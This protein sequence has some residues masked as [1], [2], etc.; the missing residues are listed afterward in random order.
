MGES[1]RGRCGGWRRSIG[2][3]GWRGIG[4]GG[5]RRA[6]GG[7][8]KRL[9]SI[10]SQD[11][12]FH[13]GLTNR[14]MRLTGHIGGVEVRHFERNQ[15]VCSHFATLPPWI[16]IGGTVGGYWDYRVVDRNFVAVAEPRAATGVAGAV[17]E[18]HA[19]N[20]GGYDHVHQ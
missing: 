3:F 9:W 1:W 8:I 17:H 2:G 7:W 12:P 10:D 20:R 19:A 6:R 11:F 5:W 18:Q 4:Q 13:G 14:K 15:H 16:Y